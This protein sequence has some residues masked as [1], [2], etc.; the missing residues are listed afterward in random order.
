[1]GFIFKLLDSR[2]FVD[3][4]WIPEFQI[5]SVG[6]HISRPSVPYSTRENFPDCRCHIHHARIC[7]I[8]ESRSLYLA[9]FILT[10]NK[11]CYLTS[12]NH[13]QILHRQ[14]SDDSSSRLGDVPSR[15]CNS[16]RGIYMY[17]EVCSEEMFR[18]RWVSLADLFSSNS[19]CVIIA[20]CVK[21]IQSTTRKVLLLPVVLSR[22]SNNCNWYCR[23]MFCDTARW[24]GVFCCFG[25]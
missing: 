21:I 18:N 14:W 13:S 23:K 8:P 6:L 19:D 24:S 17:T 2:F 15:T 10:I 1:M 22:A 12:V 9:R 20:A 7:L 11:I 5:P 16:T 3:R 4:T 25:M